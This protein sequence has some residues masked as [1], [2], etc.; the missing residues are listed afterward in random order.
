MKPQ[1]IAEY[2]LFSVADVI[3]DPAPEEA[4][5]VGF[6]VIELHTDPAGVPHVVL[7]CGPDRPMFLAH[8]DMVQAEKL[9]MAL[10]AACSKGL[11]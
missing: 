6:A 7:M 3:A 8:L 11:N 1:S 5:V 9:A 2:P 10:L 4:E